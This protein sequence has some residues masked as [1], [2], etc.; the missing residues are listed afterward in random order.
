MFYNPIFWFYAAAFLYSLS[1][2]TFFLRTSISCVIACYLT[3]YTHVFFLSSTVWLMFDKMKF[4]AETLWGP[5]NAFSHQSANLLWRFFI[6]LQILMFT[7]IFS[8]HL[9]GR[10]NTPLIKRVCIFPNDAIELP[11]VTI[12]MDMLATLFIIYLTILTAKI[13]KQL[14]TIS[15]EEKHAEV[16]NYA[17]KTWVESVVEQM[18]SNAKT[19]LICTITEIIT[20]WAITISVFHGECESL[21]SCQDDGAFSFQMYILL[22]NCTINC[23]AI[24]LSS[25]IHVMNVCSILR[26]YMQIRMIFEEVREVPTTR[27]QIQECIEMPDRDAMEYYIN[28]LAENENQEVLMQIISTLYE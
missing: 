4:H 15:N 26:D 22:V 16:F 20:I 23:F 18:G 17:G 25:P 5:E 6:F 21:F 14:S 3:P 19:C 7:K 24:T 13:Y 11:S 8:N 2:F 28:S 12:L 10:C 1:F 27:Q 9:Y